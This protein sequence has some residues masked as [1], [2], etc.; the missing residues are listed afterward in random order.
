MSPML[1]AALRYARRGWQVFPLDGKRP[2][3][4]TNGHLEATTDEK[5]L[6]RWWRKYPDANIGIA[7]SS[8]HGPIVIDIDGP[9]GLKLLETLELQPTRMARS[10]KKGKHLYFD[11]HLEGVPVP[12]TIRVKQKGVKHEFD[13]LGD[14]GYVVA[15][16]SI[17]PETGRRYRWTSKIR[18]LPLPTSVIQLVRTSQNKKKAAPPLPETIVEGERDE[19]LTSLAGSMRRRGAGEDSILAAL[20]EENAIRVSPPLPDKQ[21]VKIAKSMARKEPAGYGEH[22]TDL[23]NARRFIHQ[24]A[25]RIRHISSLRKSWFIWEGTHWAPD[26]TGEIERYAKETVRSLYTEAAQTN[27]ADLREAVLK[28]AAKSESANRVRSLLELAATEPEISMQGTGFDA[29]PWL[30]NVENGTVDLRTGELRKHRRDDF[31][32][33]LIRVE[34]NLKAKAPRWKQFLLEVMGGDHELVSFIQTAVGYSL[35]GDTREQC[36]F[37]CYGKGAN[38]KSTFFEILRELLGDYGQQSDFTTFL[39]RRGEGPRND[40][41]RMRGA[42]LI[43]AN[44]ADSEKGFDATVL[45]QLT[46]GDTIV[47][48]RLY[49]E[50]FEFRPQHKLWLA[51]NHKPIVKEQTEAF[52]RRIRLLPFSVIFPP[53]KRDRHLDQKLRLELPGILAWAVRGCSRW[54]DEGLK[55][56]KAVYDA[57]HEYKEENDLLGEF[58]AVRVVLGERHWSSTQEL[59]QAF[60]EWWMETRGSRQ[61]PPSA[62]WFTR[63]LAERPELQATKKNQIRGWRGITVK[64]EVGA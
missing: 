47:A 46:G 13:V 39:A 19:L 1:K 34:F 24:Y 25:E 15:P 54:L 58:M 21:L 28:H 56:P 9:S 40:L 11:P 17:H 63:L 49:E 42:R 6:R 10:G 3:K 18:P 7:C 20:R 16:P 55:I 36:L 12:R 8:Q 59:Y 2:F 48:R 64:H 37:F 41:A 38:G 31:I 22:L 14:G 30:L 29:D 23:G 5:Q 27:D 61:A 44:E 43:T 50:H 53:D 45:K 4:G 57:T 60:V 51:A 62:G 26:D 35:T 52:W 32:T 33:K